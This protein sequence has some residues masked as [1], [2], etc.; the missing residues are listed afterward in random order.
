MEPPPQ[1]PEQYMF[2]CLMPWSSVRSMKNSLRGLKEAIH[3]TKDGLRVRLSKAERRRHA[4][5]EKVEEAEERL[6]W[7]RE[8]PRADFEPFLLPV[9]Q[10]PSKE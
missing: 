9:P 3:G 2:I 1:L 5:L 10:L 7:M 8:H 4:E 6:R